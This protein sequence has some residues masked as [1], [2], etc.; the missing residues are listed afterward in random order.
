MSTR[1]ELSKDAIP[2][3]PDGVELRFD[4]V[5]KAW[6]VSVP[7]RVVMPD[8][9][10]IEL[11]KRCDGKTPIATIIDDLAQ[12]FSANPSQLK[13]DIDLMLQDLTDQGMVEVQLEVEL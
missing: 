2:I 5:E 8:D 9:I 6:T 4:P 3:L 12:A 1:L 13:G 11:L 10:T 7:A